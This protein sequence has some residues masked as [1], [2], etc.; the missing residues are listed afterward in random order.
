MS[1]EIIDFHMHP[2]YNKENNLRTEISLW[3]TGL[4]PN[5]LTKNGL[6]TT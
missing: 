2:F 4:Y 6:C 5:N 3:K 1:F